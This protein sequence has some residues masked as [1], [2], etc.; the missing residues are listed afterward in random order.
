MVDGL[1]RFK[2]V[3][4]LI[5]NVFHCLCGNRSILT[6]SSAAQSFIARHITYLYLSVIICRS[7]GN[8]GLYIY[9]TITHTSVNSTLQNIWPQI[10]VDSSH[11]IPVIKI[12]DFTHALQSNCF[13]NHIF[14]FK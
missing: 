1:L 4:L 11:V 9:P 3:Q 8:N 7:P 14:F 2:V 6:L 10:R 13:R 5:P 12:K